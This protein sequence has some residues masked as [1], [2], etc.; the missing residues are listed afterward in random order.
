MSEKATHGANMLL[1]TTYWGQD[2]TFKLMP[3]NKDCPYMEV[4]YDP[5]VKMLVAMSKDMKQNYEMLPR[6]DD[7]GEW[8]KSKVTK[9]NG[10]PFK[11]ERRL[12]EVPQEFYMIKREEQEAFIKQFAVNEKDYDY[13][14]FMD[15]VVAEE[16]GIMQEVK[17]DAGTVLGKD[18]KPLK[19]V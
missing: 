10:R 16:S 4:L 1:I 6:L 18:G 11:E 8:V 19:A 7:N 14:S 17:E 13:K 3:V 9:R 12:M 5:K 15:K 2:E